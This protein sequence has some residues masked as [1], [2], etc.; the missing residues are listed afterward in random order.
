MYGKDRIVRD[1][2][3]LLR[4]EEFFCSFGFVSIPTISDV[5]RFPLAPD[6]AVFFGFADRNMI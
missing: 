3:K 2:G 5:R 4:F 1:D 6:W